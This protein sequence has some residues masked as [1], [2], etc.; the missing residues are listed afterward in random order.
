MGEPIVTVS[1][2]INWDI[3]LYIS[4]F[5]KPGEEVPVSRIER[6]PG[7]KGAN[8]A[9]A[10]SRILGEGRCAI[11]GGIGS[12]EIG[13]KQI[14]VFQQEGVD[15]RWLTCFDGVESGQA[16]ILVDE[17]GENQINTY[18]GA[19][20]TL[21]KEDA[22]RLKDLLAKAKFL[23]MMDPPI[24]FAEA[25]LSSAEKATKIWSPGV[26]VYSDRKAVIL[27]LKEID[28]LVLNEHELLDLSGEIDTF[29]SL[30]KLIEEHPTLK[31]IVTQ[32]SRGVTL[33][34]VDTTYTE[35]G[36]DLG[37][38][39]LRVANTTGCGDAFVGA[40]ISHLAMGMSERSALRMANLAAALKASRYETR[41]S[42]TRRELDHYRRMLGW[43][44][45]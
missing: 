5:G 40:F 31:V 9:V 32:G 45:S 12:D 17:K 41:G 38:I 30:R 8:V 24:Q 42:P 23:A 10:A 44:E 27:H 19:N 7:G 18:F 15:T 29:K 35:E 34:K 2:A 16:Y 20:I 14:E 4:R 37:R 6:V 1:G 25:L 11:V 21:R 28:Y 26:R 39:G 22:E 33:Y 3:L 13:R 36:I 43:Q